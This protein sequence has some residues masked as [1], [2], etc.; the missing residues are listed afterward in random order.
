MEVPSLW[1]VRGRV[2]VDAIR[3]LACLGPVSMG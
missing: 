1:N 2:I 3:G